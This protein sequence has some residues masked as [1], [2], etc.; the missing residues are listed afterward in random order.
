MLETIELLSIHE[1]KFGTSF[2]MFSGFHSS[3]LR[4]HFSN[5]GA[6]VVLINKIVVKSSLFCQTPNHQISQKLHF[7]NKN[8]HPKTPQNRHEDFK[9]SGEMSSS[10]GIRVYPAKLGEV[11]VFFHVTP[12][13]RT[14]LVSSFL[15]LS[16]PGSTPGVASLTSMPRWSCTT[17]CILPAMVASLNSADA[18]CCYAEPCSE[19]NERI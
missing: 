2:I 17:A 19:T 12:Q 1:F 14:C 16:R 7:C 6:E 11:K 4:S 13:I 10:G 3:T 9:I 5:S 15:T 8:I 18:I